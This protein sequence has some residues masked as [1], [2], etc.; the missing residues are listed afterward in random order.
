[1]IWKSSWKF[2]FILVSELLRSIKQFYDPSYG[3]ERG[4]HEIR[5]TPRICAQMLEWV[6]F[7]EK[8]VRESG[9]N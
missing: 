5:L 2:W 9:I 6:T 4:V 7:T 1:M 8:Q 3:G